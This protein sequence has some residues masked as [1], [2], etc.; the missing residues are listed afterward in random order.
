M[1]QA[2]RRQV[3][4]KRSIPSMRR[5]SLPFHEILERRMVEDALAAEGV[6]FNDRSTPRS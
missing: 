2:T 6:K 4:G 1:S 5:K 3:F